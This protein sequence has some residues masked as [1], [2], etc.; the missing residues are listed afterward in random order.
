LKYEDI[1]TSLPVP[2]KQQEKE[3]LEHIKK[4]H[5]V[6]HCDICV[7]RIFREKYFVENLLLLFCV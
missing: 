3:I 4:Y 1:F 7:E 2:S 6:C 5:G